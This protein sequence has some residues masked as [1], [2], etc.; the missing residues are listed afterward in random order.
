MA[1]TPLAPPKDITIPEHGSTTAKTVLSAAISKLLREVPA[2]LHHAPPGARPEAAEMQRILALCLKQSPGAVM[3]ALRRPT[4][5]AL[6]R[7]LRA[8]SLRSREAVMR[9]LC[10]VFALELCVLGALPGPVRLPRFPAKLLSLPARLAIVP[11]ADATALVLENGKVVIERPAG[12]AVIDI[13]SQDDQPFVE[14][15]YHP[16]DGGIVLAT[17][18]NNPLSMMEAHPDKEGNAID[19]GGHPAEEWA[20]ELGWGMAKIAR[21][22]PDLHGEMRLFIQQMVPVG[23]HEQRHLSA[24]YQ[25]AIGTIY[26]S[27]HPSRMTLA[28]ALIHEFS[29]NK[30]NALFE[31]DE[32]LENAWSPLY[33]SPVRPDPRPLHG[34]LLA[35]HAFLPVARLYEKMIAEGDPIAQNPSFL[36]RYAAIRKINREGA[37]LVLDKGHPTRIGAGLLD[38][39]RR[40]DEHY[41]HVDEA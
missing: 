29:H 32:V 10:A 38:E 7:S 13:A 41:R 30:L 11:P 8:E 14:R 4:V 2:L 20:G 26:L 9:E 36:G 3:S 19:L 12:A 25:E 5:G 17:A 37:E 40:W 22:L 18:D 23:W 6:L 31:L 33:T 34:V 35:V 16:I 15:P 27:L 28:E 39:I 21:Y 1:A 24:S